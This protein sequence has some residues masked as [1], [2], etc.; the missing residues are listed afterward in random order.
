[1]PGASKRLAPKGGRLPAKGP[2]GGLGT[3]TW[4]RA[5][6]GW[7]VAPPSSGGARGAGGV[8]CAPAGPGWMSSEVTVWPAWARASP[9]PSN[10][11]ARPAIAKNKRTFEVPLQV[12]HRLNSCDSSAE[13]NDTKADRL[14]SEPPGRSVLQG[15]SASMRSA[16][17]HQ[18]VLN[19]RNDQ[20]ADQENKH[21]SKEHKPDVLQA[22]RETRGFRLMRLHDRHQIYL[23]A[24]CFDSG[25]LQRG[26]GGGILLVCQ[27]PLDHQHLVV[28]QD[29]CIA[30]VPFRAGAGEAVFFGAD[31][32][33]D[34]IQPIAQRRDLH[35][36]GIHVGAGFAYL[37]SNLSILGFE[38]GDDRE[39]A[40]G[41]LLGVQFL[42]GEP[43][44]QQLA[45]DLGH[46]RFAS[47]DF[48]AGDPQ[49]VIL[50]PLVEGVHQPLADIVQSGQ[51]VAGVAG[52]VGFG[53]D[54]Y[55][56][57]CLVIDDADPPLIVLHQVFEACIAREAG[58]EVA[59]LTG[60][61]RSK[62]QL[63]TKLQHR[64]VRGG[65]F[66]DAVRLDGGAAELDAAHGGTHQRWRCSLSRRT[67]R[68]SRFGVVEVRGDEAVV[69]RGD[70]RRQAD[71]QQQRQERAQSP[72]Q[73]PL[74]GVM[75]PSLRLEGFA[76]RRRCYERFDGLFLG[77]LFLGTRPG[78]CGWSRPGASSCL[79]AGRRCGRLGERIEFIEELAFA[80]RRHLLLV[81]GSAIRSR[82][83]SRGSLWRGRFPLFPGCSASFRSSRFRRTRLRG[84]RTLLGGVLVGASVTAA[85]FRKI[86][87]A[88]HV[89]LPRVHGRGATL[90]RHH[91]SGASCRR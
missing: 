65:K 72:E 61:D 70:H 4:G 32:L 71:D 51:K 52:T 18:V 9:A 36:V 46:A 81:G 11:S 25:A 64:I 2:P 79:L 22:S 10:I 21:R 62:V 34:G 63:F 85:V 35:A 27:F 59:F 88:G 45:A 89:L 1:M 66:G 73:A 74:V 91:R 39:D 69:D 77:A 87:Y 76:L 78:P 3:T 43:E 84:G 15:G 57:A 48:A 53:A 42:V 50:R 38:L 75:G 90:H 5:R 47:L 86:V 49:C 6:A 24:L 23:L 26:D 54:G 16:L 80:R 8:V 67:D 12:A 29:I 37:R 17:V 13:G 83:W 19:T 41:A 14:C 56:A 44:A 31:L 20:A 7:A 68:Y 82:G 40:P 58:E 60:E 30:T 55:D 28:I 33:F